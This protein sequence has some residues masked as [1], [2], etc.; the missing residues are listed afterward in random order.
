MCDF[1]LFVI[2]LSK[3]SELFT[4][5]LREINSVLF[6]LQINSGKSKKIHISFR[7]L[8]SVTVEVISELYTER[9]MWCLLNIMNENVVGIFLLQFPLKC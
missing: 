8:G 1:D 5:T 9:T 6:V 7:W 4:C 2:Y 3:V